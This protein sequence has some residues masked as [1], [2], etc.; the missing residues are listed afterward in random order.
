MRI[1]LAY[2]IYR[3]E[4]DQLK[5]S[6]KNYYT[7]ERWIDISNQD[8]GVTWITCDAPVVETGNI[9]TDA[10]AYGWI[11]EAKPSQTILSYV[12]N[13]YWGTNYKAGQEGIASFR[14]VIRPHGMF[15]PQEAERCASQEKE[16]LLVVPADRDKKPIEP[17]MKV[18]G[19]GI[20]V[21]SLVPQPDG[22]LIHIFNSGYAPSAAGISWK[23]TPREVFLCD[24]DG[25]KTGEFNTGTLIP[26]WGTRT[27]RV[28]R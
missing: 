3:P 15:I 17:L 1:D 26:G 28:R 24:Y 12:M 18:T 13:N 9:T 21:T 6:C 10:N 22:Y 14:Y 23:E 27:I 7:P 4:S 11:R 2:G 8:R 19:Q 5:G 25:E 20:I 16:P